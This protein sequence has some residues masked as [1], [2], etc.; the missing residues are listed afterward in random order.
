MSDNSVSIF[1]SGFVLNAR[2]S[3][4]YKV[5]FE[6]V[7]SSHAHTIFSISLYLY[8]PKIVF[9]VGNPTILKMLLPIYSEN[10]LFIYDIFLFFSFIGSGNLTKYF[11]FLYI[12][13]FFF[14]EPL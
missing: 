7:K 6:S 11:L 2:F 9:W 10:A 3:N 5:L 14:S 12:S 1:L 4:S 13:V 8:I